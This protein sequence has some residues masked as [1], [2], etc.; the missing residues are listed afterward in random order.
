MPIGFDEEEREHATK[1]A[2]YLTK[3]APHFWANLSPNGRFHDSQSFIDDWVVSSKILR[4]ANKCRVNTLYKSQSPQ[5]Q[6]EQLITISFD[7][8][9]FK[10]TYITDLVQLLRMKCP[11]VLDYD[12]SILRPEFNSVEQ[13][14]PSFNPHVHIYTPKKVKRSAVDANLRKKLI[15][16]KNPPFNSCVYNVNTQEAPAPSHMNYIL[17]IKQSSKSDK[18]NADAQYRQK[19]N[20]D[21][22]YYISMHK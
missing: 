17:G 4:D 12:E 7:K 5:P 1:L 21:E 14:D 2:E 10:P 3:E 19:H 6:T 16:C 11:A 22:I 13:S 18:L 8:A 9:T 20:L 15:T